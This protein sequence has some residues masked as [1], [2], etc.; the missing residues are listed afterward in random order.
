MRRIW[1]RPSSFPH[2][3]REG[4]VGFLSL[5][6]IL[7]A[8]GIKKRNGPLPEKAGSRTREGKMSGG[9][10]ILRIDNSF[11]KNKN[12]KSDGGTTHQDAGCGFS[13]G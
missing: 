8:R 2:E 3:G 10:I 6:F 13:L 7:R 11:V 1:A 5:I 9:L 4:W 12:E